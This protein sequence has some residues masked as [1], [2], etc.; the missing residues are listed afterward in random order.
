MKKVKRKAKKPAVKGVMPCYWC[1]GK[2]QYLTSCATCRGSGILAA[3]PPQP[4]EPR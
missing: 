1:H 2:G 4:W 3:R